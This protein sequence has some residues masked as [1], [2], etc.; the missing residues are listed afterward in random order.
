[1]SRLLHNAVSWLRVDPIGV[2]MPGPQ[3]SQRVRKMI[4]ALPAPWMSP[5][6]IACAA[7]FSATLSFALLAITLTSAQ[8]SATEWEKAAGGKMSFEVASIK[9]DSAEPSPGNTNSNVP[10]GTQGVFKPTGGLFS[11][12]NFGLAT[13]LSFAYKLKR[14]QAREI[15]S[16]LPKWAAT[17]RWD[18]QARAAGDPTWDQYRLMMQSLLTERFKVSAHFETR[19]GPVLAMVVA[20][21][22][23]LGLRLRPHPANASCSTDAPASWPPAA[24]EG[25]FP[26]RCGSVMWD[27]QRR[28]DGFI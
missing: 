9:Q 3:L 7:G 10:L 16:Q 14:G 19:E 20:K 25:G 28:R 27:Q 5:A 6:R 15:A 24:G 21:E 18:V 26:S 1:M 23:K 4:H 2:A 11:S 22:G 8:S 17:E 12:S 13:Y